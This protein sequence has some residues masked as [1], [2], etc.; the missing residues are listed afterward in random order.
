MAGLWGNN[1]P[2]HGRPTTDDTNK[3]RSGKRYTWGV[4]DP[5]PKTGKGRRKATKPN[6]NRWAPTDW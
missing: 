6:P 4:G 2:K 5:K 3:Q 1:Q